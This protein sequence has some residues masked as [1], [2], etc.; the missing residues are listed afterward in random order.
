MNAA[1]VAQRTGLGILAAKRA[2]GDYAAWL[3]KFQQDY[4]PLIP[5]SAD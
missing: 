2:V 4:A 5:L 1:T 3:K